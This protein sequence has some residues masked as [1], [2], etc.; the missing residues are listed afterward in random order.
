MLADAN[1]HSTT[2]S[3]LQLVSIQNISFVFLEICRNVYFMQGRGGDLRYDLA[4]GV[5]ISPA[6]LYRLGFAWLWGNKDHVDRML[7]VVEQE[8]M[9]THH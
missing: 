6:I 8:Q 7:D 3:C 4:P 9:T 5:L 2:L 1:G